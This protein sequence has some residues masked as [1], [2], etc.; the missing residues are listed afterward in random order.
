MPQ[1]NKNAQAL[2]PHNLPEGFRLDERGVIRDQLGRMQKGGAGLNP[3]GRSNWNKKFVE[4]LRKKFK[5]GSVILDELYKMIAY[6]Y[7]KDFRVNEEGKKIWP[8][9]P[10]VKESDKIAAIKIATAYMAGLPTSTQVIDKNVD[11]QINAKMH[12]VAELIHRN[13]HELRLVEGK[14]E[15]VTD[16]EETSDD[17][18]FIKDIISDEC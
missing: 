18:E 8:R 5:N 9:F 17:S 6:D 11:I 16:I 13:K 3:S 4:N 12:K 10:R 1:A 15:E 7:D 14:D 2:D